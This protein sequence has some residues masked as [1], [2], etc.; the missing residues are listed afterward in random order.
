[1]SQHMV[2]VLK[3]SE[4]VLWGHEAPSPLRSC[5]TYFHSAFGPQK[6]GYIEKA[7]HS[8]SITVFIS[9]ATMESTTFLGNANSAVLALAL[10]LH[11]LTQ[12]LHRGC[13]KE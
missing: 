13:H 11:K 7:T 6:H 12:T 10:P 8:N 2:R 5:A 3:M 1:M 4:T 9:M